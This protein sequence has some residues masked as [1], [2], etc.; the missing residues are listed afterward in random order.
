MADIAFNTTAAIA[1]MTETA[2][3]EFAVTPA[4]RT[5]YLT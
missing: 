3:P 1:E 4:S 2:V 5:F